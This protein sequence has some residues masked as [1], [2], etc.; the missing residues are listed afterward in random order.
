L[1]KIQLKKHKFDTKAWKGKK[2][3]PEHYD[4]II[5][6]DADLYFEGKIV[7]SYRSICGETKSLLKKA[8]NTAKCKKSART[9]GAQQNSAV[10]GALPRVPCREDYCR[11]SGDTKS[12]PHVFKALSKVGV[13][14]WG[15]YKDKFPEVS[16]LF[17]EKVSEIHSDWKKTG[18]PFTT[19]NVNKGFAI[20]Y[21]Y[22]KANFGGVYSNVIIEKKN[23]NG[24]LFVMPEFRVALDQADGAL[25]IVD[26][27]NVYHGVTELE[28]TSKNWSR[29][30][31]VFYTLNN[32]KHCLGQRGEISRSKSITMERARKRA[33]K[34]DPRNNNA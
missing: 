14:L 20:G 3:R 32:L 25:A 28:P 4:T 33:K 23:C 13:Y 16:K 27:V 18:T 31:I 22:D 24:G 17:S 6:G 21:H 5:S 7:C 26:G 15:V 19:V 1:K 12:Q 2:A 9:R 29:S 10:Y 30:S 34:I 8:A 11:F